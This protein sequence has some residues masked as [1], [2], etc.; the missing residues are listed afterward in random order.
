MLQKGVPISSI[1]PGHMIISFPE[2]EAP[3]RKLV[4]STKL[5]ILADPSSLIDQGKVFF[6]PGDTSCLRDMGPCQAANLE[7]TRNL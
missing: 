3:D 1:P 5:F 7:S 2:I 6:L 4:F